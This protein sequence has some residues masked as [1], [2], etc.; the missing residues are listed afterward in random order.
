MKTIAIANNKG[1]CGKTATAYYLGKL[2]AEA[3]RSTL[4]IDLDP[5]ANLT[6][7]FWPVAP[8]RTVA[9]VLS[10]DPKVGHVKEA[11]YAVEPR[12]Q[13]WLCPG[14]F[15]LANVALG[16]LNDAVRGRT[17]L[18]RALQQ[19]PDGFEVVLIDCPPEAGILL[20]NALLAADGV[21]LP[22]EPEPPALDGANRI[23]EMVTLIQ[24]EYERPEPALLGTVATRVD[25]RTNRH[26]DGVK[27][28][29]ESKRLPLIASIPE[30]N[31][32]NR[33][34]DLMNAYQPVAE[35][36]RHWADRGNYDARLAKDE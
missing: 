26:L 4:L 19:L 22:A 29:Q 21:I 6:E 32:E 36:I 7:R 5:Q 12:R 24:Q 8:G 34:R 25:A 18:R 13:L 27:A 31:G 35:W 2:L 23:A 20:V 3:G 17:A 14:E 11:L 16:L 9:D 1:G 30:R 28:M 15:Q 10:G 33:D